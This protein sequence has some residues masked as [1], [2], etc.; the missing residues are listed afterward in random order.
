MNRRLT[1]DEWESELGDNIRRARLE[2]DLS[3]ADLAKRAAVSVGALGHLERGE[4]A[5]VRTMIR[6]VRALDRTDWLIAFAP[7]PLV[8]P[9][10]MLR[11]QQQRP[12]PRRR[13]RRTTS[14]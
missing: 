10:Q 2:A 12:T 11:D 8:S 7:T 13:A 4:G 3:M 9:I 5:T 6:V 14:A 1:T